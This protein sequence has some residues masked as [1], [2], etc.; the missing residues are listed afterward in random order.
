MRIPSASRNFYVSAEGEVRAGKGGSGG[1]GARAWMGPGK[2]GGASAS[3]HQLG[4]T[5]QAETE[6]GRCFC[7]VD[8]SA[9]SDIITGVRDDSIHA[10]AHVG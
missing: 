9:C 6:L 7:K 4:G 3:H 2:G 10:C 1:Y 5:F 8:L